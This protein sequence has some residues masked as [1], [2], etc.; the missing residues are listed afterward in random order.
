MD[1]GDGPLDLRCWVDVPSVSRRRFTHTCV[2]CGSVGILL[3]YSATSLHSS[4]WEVC[5]RR[6]WAVSKNQAPRPLRNSLASLRSQQ[7]PRQSLASCTL[8]I[9]TSKTVIGMGLIFLILR[10]PPALGRAAREK[11]LKSQGQKRLPKRRMTKMTICT[12]NALTLAS[13]ACIEDLVMQASKIK[14]DV[15]G[16]TETRRHRLLH[17]VFETGEELFLG[18]C[19]SIGVGGVSVLANAHLAMNIDS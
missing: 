2:S 9:Y 19:D 17:D 4:D 6:F 11:L 10:E 8:G 12:F 1:S 13:E 15:I 3:I 18:T 7:P 5:G 16:L 14:Y